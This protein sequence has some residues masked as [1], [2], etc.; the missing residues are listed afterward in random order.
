M[1]KLRW[2]LLS[3]ARINRAVIPPIRASLQSELKAVASRDVVRAKDYAREWHIPHAYG[4]Y[5]ELLADKNID[6]IYN[7]LPNHLHAEWSIRAAEAGKHVLCEKPLALSL[8]EVDQIMAAAKKHNVIITEA[9]MYKHH[10]QTLK[11]LDLIKQD[12]I[13]DLLLIKG[14]FTFNL[15]RPDDVRWVPEW[16]GGSIWDVGCYPISFSRLV[17]DAEPVEVFGWQVTGSTGIDVV[18]SGQ[19][20]FAGGL[21]AQFDC[22]FR[23]PYRTAMEIVG[24]KGSIELGSPFKPAGGEWIKIKRGDS[25]DKVRAP[26]YELYRGEIDDMEQAVLGSQVP[27]I[28]LENSRGNVATILALLE[29][30]QTGQVVRL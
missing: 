19:M 30:A 18:F 4:S 29:S 20:R 13:G 7:P 27:R 5:E 25:V 8:D 24:T 12:A 6:A 11:V 22:G 14:A 2:G 3:T 23:A 28:S 9:F 10:P 1:K 15:D 16:G 17:A 21:L 26:E